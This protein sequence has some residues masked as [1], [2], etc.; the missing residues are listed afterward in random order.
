MSEDLSTLEQSVKE[1]LVNLRTEKVMSE[2]RMSAGVQGSSIGGFQ[3]S[4]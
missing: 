3:A 2:R 1:V 4:P